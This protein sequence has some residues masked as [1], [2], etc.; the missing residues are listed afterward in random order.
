MDG[1]IDI[2]ID[3]DIDEAGGDGAGGADT[4][5]VPGFATGGR[6]ERTGIAL[7]HE[8]EY[9]VPQAGSEAVVS[10]TS[11]E[12]VVSYHFPVRVEVVGTL[13]D[14]EVQRVAGY[15]FDQ[16]DRELSARN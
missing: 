12:T 7:V 4:F 15:V 16:L 13:P 1:D 10:P 5:A 8:G 3:I 9:I 6:V 11:E 2:D 14:A